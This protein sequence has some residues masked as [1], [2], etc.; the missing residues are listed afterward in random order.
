MPIASAVPR[1]VTLVQQNTQ[2][3][4]LSGLRDGTQPFP[5]FVNTAVLTA[6]LVD[7]TREPDSVLNQI[8]MP[9]IAA[10]NGD[11]EGT[12]PST[13]K[14]PLGSE[15]T[16]IIDGDGQGAHLHMEIVAEVIARSS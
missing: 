16:L 3:L 13:F 6:T 11:Y 4:K 9:Y 8:P 15:Y 10:S 2:G 5:N 12:V 7:Q 1:K 14:A